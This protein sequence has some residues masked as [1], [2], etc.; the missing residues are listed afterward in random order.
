[1]TN[2]FYNIHAYIATRKM[3]GLGALLLVVFSL[4]FLASKIEFEEDITKLI[5]IN[6]SNSDA[7]KVLKSVNFADKIIVNIKRESAGSIND[8]TQYASQFI[9]SIHNTSSNYFT[10]IQGKI[11]DEEILNTLYFVYSN[12]LH[13]LEPSDYNTIKNKLQKDSIEAI[14]KANYKTLISPSGMVAKETILRDPLGVSFLAL[15]K[16]QQLSFGNEFTMHNGFL[17]SKDKK[18]ILL[19]ISP[20][21]PSSETSKNAL[22]AEQLYNLNTKLNHEFKGKVSSEYF[23]GALV[24]VANAKQIKQ[25]IQLTVGIAITI[26]LLI[27]IV[28]Y[29][30][31]SV[32][33]ILF[34]PTAFG[35]LLAVALLFLISTYISAISLGIGSVLLGITLDYALHILTH[36]RSNNNVKALYKEITK[37]ILMSSLTT[38]LAFLCLLF[39]DSQALQDLGLFAA[40]SVLGASSFALV[41][42][43]L[44]YKDQS[45]K[46][47]KTTVIDNVAAYPLHKNKWVL[48]SMVLLFVMSYF[49]Y[50]K[51]TFN[52]DLANLN[53][54]PKDLREA[55]DRLDALTNINSKSVYIASYGTN[56]QDVLKANDSVFSIL[57]SLKEKDSI[58]G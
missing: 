33:L 1:M 27:L 17:L 47:Q 39:L 28:F 13:F 40:I 8:L 21:H 35:A 57:K 43:P 24:A 55:Q 3:L 6:E 42:I 25:D 34:A 49:T 51:V 12:L 30:K 4:G 16:L 38:A 14:T 11:E 15:K 48:I 5:P 46:T 54:E 32:P 9:D 10:K 44:V 26:L 37:P 18:H 52:N 29:R 31:L 53:F 41:F 22:F 58:I 20:T 50:N 19:F 2:F 45:K 36:I 23:G 56:E 7:Q